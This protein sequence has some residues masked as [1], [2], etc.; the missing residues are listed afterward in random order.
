MVFE[1]V[2]KDLKKFV[3]DHPIAFS[4]LAIYLGC[5]ILYIIIYLI[6][7]ADRSTAMSLNEIGDFLAG[8]FSP[9]AF[10]FLYLGYRQNSEALR[11]QANE[12]ATSNKSF[13]KQCKEL[14]NSVEQQKKLV[15]ITGVELNL[16]QT[17]YQK[18]LVQQQPF[19]HFREVYINR[20]IE[21]L[22]YNPDDSANFEDTDFDILD[23]VFTLYNSRSICR[24]SSILISDPF[25]D[26]SFLRKSIDVFHANENHTLNFHL[27]YPKY[28]ND[29]NLLELDIIFKYL[30]Q[31][32]NTQ[33]QTYKFFV[34][35]NTSNF[36]FSH[37]HIL[38]DKSY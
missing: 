3:Q 36:K 38:Y 18:S 15:K 28:F 24:Q 11:I 32:D 10:L 34:R 27:A 19:L 9:I 21:N 14:E 29:H 20:K 23:I 2:K 13:K 8:A 35:R 22:S 37:E 6:L 4:L 26:T 1:E 25:S 5:L 17:Q 7:F 33:S 30:D 31:L 16:L 12:L